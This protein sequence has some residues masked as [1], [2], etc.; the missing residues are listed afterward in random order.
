ME[1]TKA[2]TKLEDFEILGQLGEGAF[3]TVL[4]AREIATNV[5]CAIKSVNKAKTIELNKEVHVMREKKL[6]DELKHNNIVN[7]MKT[8]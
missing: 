3:G 5:K 8:F 7:L 6:M 2:K 4:L 1:P